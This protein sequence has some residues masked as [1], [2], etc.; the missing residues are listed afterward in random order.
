LQ[1]DDLVLR[2]NK[3]GVQVFRVCLKEAVPG[4]LGSRLLEFNSMAQCRS[5]DLVLE[6]EAGEKER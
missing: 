4:L 3:A 6:P 2:V 5:H 1:G